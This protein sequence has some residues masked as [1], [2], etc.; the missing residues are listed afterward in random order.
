LPS[1]VR[2]DDVLTVGVM[3]FILSILATIYPSRRAAHVK[4]AEALRYE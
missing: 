1:D 2:F 3:A 4:P